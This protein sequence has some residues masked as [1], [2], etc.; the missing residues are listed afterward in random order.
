VSQAGAAR[1]EAAAE[2]ALAC[3]AA[4]AVLRAGTEDRARRAARAAATWEGPH[5]ATFDGAL[6]ALE[7]RS[8][9]LEAFA[10]LCAAHLDGVSSA[11]L[12]GGG[13]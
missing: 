7:G 9:E 4:A 13:W 2:A 3:R 1:A 6:A 11:A 12:A 8:C 5:R 10:L